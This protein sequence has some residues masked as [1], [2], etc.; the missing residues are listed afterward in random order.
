MYALVW[1]HSGAEEAIAAVVAMQC[2]LP[3]HGTMVNGVSQFEVAHL[4]MI[5][6]QLR[7]ICG[8]SD[9]WHGMV[10]G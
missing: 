8:I 2:S 3:S 10:S 6:C 1:L 9:I 5:G 7:C 4:E